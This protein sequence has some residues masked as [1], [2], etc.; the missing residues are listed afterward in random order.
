MKN[1]F[2]FALLLLS[3]LGCKKEL[4]APADLS[5]NLQETELDK[6]VDAIVQKH[7]NQLNTVGMT[8]GIW[9]DGNSYIYGYGETQKGGG[10]IPDAHTFFEIGSITK[11][12]TATATVQ[13]L[14]EKG[15]SLD[16]PIH[17][18]LPSNVPVLSKDGAEVTF[19]QLMNHSS[20][21][22][23]FPSNL[24]LLFNISKSLA[25]YSEAKLF[26]YLEKGKLN[27]KPGTTFEYSN[28]AVGLQGTI[29]A[30]ENKKTYGA[31]IQEK[32]C[33]PLGLYET[34][35]VLSADEK[36]RLSK[37]YKGGKEVNYWESLGALD[38]AGVLRSTTSDLLKYGQAV[39][40]PPNNALGKA[41]RTCQEPTFKD[42]KNLG[43][44]DEV[45][46][47]WFN[48]KPGDGS[49]SLLF[50]NG[51]TGGFNTNLFVDKTRKVVLTVC[52]N[53]INEGAKEEDAARTA[54]N[55]ELLSL[56]RK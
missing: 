3:F 50:H 21:L 18:F 39:I 4:I 52:F 9:K 47:G 51:G 22:A 32:V 38:G 20:G 41:M 44:Y 8:V 27:A 10:Q 14:N 19:K 34:K 43:D 30:R 24:N 31:Y 36:L 35:V 28:T 1:T 23:Y 40:N 54:L 42:A 37:G 7:R 16:S 13:W 33:D 26:D 12:F 56:L 15:L 49:G 48:I 25:N 46:L 6:T 2:F 53:S 55:N 11:T 45:C 17:P 5:N 29:L